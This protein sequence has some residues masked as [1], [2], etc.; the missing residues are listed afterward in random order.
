MG[1]IVLCRVPSAS[2]ETT[3][4]ASSSQSR[5]RSRTCVAAASRESLLSDVSR[6]TLS[7][8]STM[9]ASTSGNPGSTTF[10]TSLAIVIGK[11]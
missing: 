8:H 3:P 7:G 10:S 4:T 5:H 9:A 6:T 11:T 1:V 2:C